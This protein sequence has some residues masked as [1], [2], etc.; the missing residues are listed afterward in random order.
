MKKFY[1]TTTLNADAARC[2]PREPQVVPSLALRRV[3]PR[4]L[5]ING[6]TLRRGAPHSIIM[7]NL[8]RALP[9]ATQTSPVYTHSYTRR[10]RAEHRPSSHIERR[11]TAFYFFAVAHFAVIAISTPAIIHGCDVRLCE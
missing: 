4:A 7:K 5:R 9:R 10:A 11:P 1:V 3:A 6:D 8:R 2:R